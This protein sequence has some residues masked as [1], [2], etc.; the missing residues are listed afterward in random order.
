MR[1]PSREA[2]LLS[3]MLAA[4]AVIAAVGERESLVSGK[5]GGATTLSVRPD[6]SRGLYELAER[7]GA[8][9]ARHHETFEFLPNPPCILV[10]IEPLAARATASERGSLWRWVKRGGELIVVTGSG[11]GTALRLPVTGLDRSTDVLGPR[12]IRV[13]SQDGRLRDVGELELAS[14]PVL[15]TRRK[16]GRAELV[17]DAR[18]AY[19]VAW[20]EGMGSVVAVSSALAP[21]NEALGRADNAILWANLLERAGGRPHKV[22]FDEFHHG[23]G[24][25]RE[26]RGMWWTALPAA[27]RAAGWLV[28]LALVAAVWNGNRRF[29]SVLPPPDAAVGARS[30]YVGSMA[31][32]IRK[33][34][35]PAL[36]VEYIHEAFVRDLAHAAGT[37]MD[38]GARTLA[39]AAARQ[40]R[41]EPDAIATLLEFGSGV[42]HGGTATEARMLAYAREVHRFREEVGLG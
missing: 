31:R 8:E 28:A 34:S 25:A 14:G 33:S 19:V 32:L 6:G 21:S 36:A 40:F 16:V 15:S 38:A 10:V 20:R 2:I 1:R 7:R 12:K 26:R 29:G 17:R 39:V 35:C 30:E 13:R 23:F 27:V 24:V 11:A 5:G 42:A 18:G 37:P 3:A 4:F 9:V 41:R 22:V